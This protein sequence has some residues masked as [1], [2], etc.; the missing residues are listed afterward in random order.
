M[1]FGSVSRSRRADALAWH[2]PDVIALGSD[3][4]RLAADLVGLALLSLRP[5]CSIEAENLVLRRQLRPPQ[6]VPGTSGV[7]VAGGPAKR[8]QS[9]SLLARLRTSVEGRN[10]RDTCSRL[11]AEKNRRRTYSRV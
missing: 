7:V 2:D 9:A 5:S 10:G 8:S 11:R 4:L 6:A 3:R 1:K